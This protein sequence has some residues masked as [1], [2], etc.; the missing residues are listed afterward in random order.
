MPTVRQRRGP[1]VEA[2]H[3]FSAVVV[4]GDAVAERFG[5]DVTT[6]YRS[7]A[8]PFQLAVSLEA[9]GDPDVSDEELAVGAASHSAEP[10]HLSLVA[11]LLERFDLDE[12]ALRCGAHPPMHA[13]SAERILREGGRFTNLHNNCSG[14]HTFMRAACDAQGWA[15]DYR[16]PEHP[17][18]RRV[19]DAIT[20]ASGARGELATD[21]CG[22]PTFGL[23][24]SAIAR[25]WARIAEAMR[26]DDARLGRI[27]RA[28]ARHPELTSGTGRLDLDVVRHV[29]EPVAV[30]I[31][32]QGLFCLAFPERGLGVALKVH[33]GSG[34][35]LPAA[36]SAVLSRVMGDAWGE[37]EGWALRDVRNVVGRSV[38]AWDVE[39]ED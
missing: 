11:G 32:A 19:A 10:A 2:V 39:L 4:Q 22:V 6:T 14:K 12:A 37:P 31:G 27:G 30:K 38:G 9:L 28:M 7:S 8:K 34:D 26:D 20:E 15:P 1:I 17:L 5:S 36:T 35:A 21:G 16:D 18:Q 29:R 3:P 23:P 13:P 24:L 33:S 25:G